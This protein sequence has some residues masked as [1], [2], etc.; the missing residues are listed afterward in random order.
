L[1]L[2]VDVDGILRGKILVKSKFLSTLE[3]G[4]GFCSIIFG[5]DMHDKTYTEELEI[6][7]SDNGTN[8][9]LLVLNFR[10]D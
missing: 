4:F 8:S 1:K 6:S 7:N 5:W 10:I 3:D 9:I 2:G